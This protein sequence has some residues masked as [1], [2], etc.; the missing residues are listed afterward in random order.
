MGMLYMKGLLV[1][2]GISPDEVMFA[3]ALTACN[4]SGLFD[5]GLQS[6]VSMA[7]DYNIVP[8]M[9]HYA[10]LLDLLGRTGNFGMVEN[11]LKRMPVGTDLSLWLGLLGACGRH[12]NLHLA[13][14]VF[15]IALALQPEE[16]TTYVMMSNIYAQYYS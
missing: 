6:F 13:Q 4:H 9:K 7:R 10:I 15:E 5:A 3:S 14:Q 16:A 2:F 8:N 11:V 1:L 12:T